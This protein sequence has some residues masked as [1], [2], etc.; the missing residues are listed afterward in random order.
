MLMVSKHTTLLAGTVDPVVLLHV[1][2]ETWY[3]WGHVMPALAK[4]YTIIAPDLRGLGASS[5][6]LTGYDGKTVAQDIHQGLTSYCNRGTRRID[7]FI[8]KI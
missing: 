8:Y 3:E 7:T 2:P 6:P 5:K 4:T 1:W